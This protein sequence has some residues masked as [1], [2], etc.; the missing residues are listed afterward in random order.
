MN[1][2][3]NKTPERFTYDFK[4]F[5]KDENVAKINKV[6]VEAANNFNL[7]VYK[8]DIEQPQEVVPEELTNKELLDLEQE[9]VA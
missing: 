7:D 1:A 6:T 5:V 4:G 2:I 8:D 3:W 9:Y